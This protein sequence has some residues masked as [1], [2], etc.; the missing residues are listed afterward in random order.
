MQY[1]FE[2]NNFLPAHIFH[3]DIKKLFHSLI[4]ITICLQV[5]S[6]Y[7]TTHCCHTCTIQTSIAS[8]CIIDFRFIKL[9]YKLHKKDTS[10]H[11]R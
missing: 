6:M 2:V 10:E 11:P 1:V 3:C 9:L 8:L 7:G 4:V 5:Y